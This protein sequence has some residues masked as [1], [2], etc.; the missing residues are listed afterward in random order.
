MKRPKR[1]DAPCRIRL[2]PEFPAWVWWPVT[3][4]A[5]VVFALIGIGLFLSFI[6]FEPLP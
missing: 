6:N 4:L 2:E 1:I 3:L 5:I